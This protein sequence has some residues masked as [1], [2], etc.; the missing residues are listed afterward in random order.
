MLS[1][2]KINSRIILSVAIIHI[3]VIGCAV[4]NWQPRPKDENM[5]RLKLGGE[6]LSH[7][8]EVGKP[9]RRAPGRTPEPEPEK[10]P[11]KEPEPEPTPAPPAPP[12]EPG[13]DYEALNRTRKQEEARKKRLDAEKKRNAELEKKKKEE[14]RKKWLEKKKRL[15]AE[16]K[17][18]A[19]EERKRKERESIY[20]PDQ[21]GPIGGGGSNLNPNVPVGS[22]DR[23]Q[24]YGNP[25][26][27]APGGGARLKIK[28]YAERNLLP[29]LKSR[30]KQPPDSLLGGKRP[31]VEISLTIGAGGRV[32]R[33]VIERA[34]GVSAMDDSV[35][36]LLAGLDIL[37]VPPEGKLDITI[38]LQTE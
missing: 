30:W 11:E 13:I 3:L 4:M 12:K 10:E 28:E 20:N 6:E 37:P 9:E 18:N 35:K 33:A 14:A 27:R 38:T 32:E 1:F 23:A 15:D 29:Y 7:G 24:K 5:L 16:K 31:S 34:S 25:D 21:S 8:E 36:R 2:R 26:N 22:K 19:E 17:R